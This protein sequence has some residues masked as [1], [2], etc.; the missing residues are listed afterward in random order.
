MS[1]DEVWLAKEAP[2]K[3]A[4]EPR[5]ALC[6]NEPYVLAGDFFCA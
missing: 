4:E 2:C 6:E 1:D 3:H 5:I